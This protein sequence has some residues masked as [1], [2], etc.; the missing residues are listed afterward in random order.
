MWQ[1]REALLRQRKARS[2]AKHPTEPLPRRWAELVLHLEEIERT[3]RTKS[4]GR[5][6]MPSGTTANLDRPKPA[7]DNVT[8]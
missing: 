4:G 8:Q 3:E 5:S 2:H 6:Q 1:L 7:N